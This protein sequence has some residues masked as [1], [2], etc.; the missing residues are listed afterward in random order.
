[1][2]ARKSRAGESSKAQSL[3]VEFC[4]ARWYV[5]CTNANHEKRVAHQLGVRGVQHFLPTYSSMRRWTDR[6][7]TLQLPLFPGYVFVRMA[8]RDRLLVLQVPGAVRLVGFSGIPSAIPQQDIDAI[9]SCLDHGLYLEP[10]PYLHAGR[11]AR[12]TNGPLQ[13]LEGIILRKKNRTRFVL[14]FQVMMRA[15]A[16]EMDG[17]ELE[18][19]NS[20]LGRNPSEG[21]NKL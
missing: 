11:R 6:R 18:P 21:P 10:H 13:G 2:I 8:L 4:S 14:S 15:V 17:M 9:Q 19:I 16:V 20:R 7:V 5:L 3:S 1:M 12:V